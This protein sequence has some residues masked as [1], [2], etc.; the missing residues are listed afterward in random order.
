MKRQCY[1]NIVKFLDRKVEQSNVLL[2]QGARQVGKT[3]AVEE[4]LSHREAVTAINLER[5]LRTK[6]AIDQTRDFDEFTQL[7]KSRG[8]LPI[9]KK[10]ILFLDEA[11]E[12]EKLGSYVRFMKEEWRNVKVILSG[13]SMQRLFAEK[14][15]VPVGR[16][17]YQQIFPFSF[18]EYLRFLSKEDLLEEAKSLGAKLKDV[19]HETLLKYYDDF[20]FHGGMPEVVKAVAAKQGPDEVL[21]AL[22]ASQRD[23]FLRKERV[24]SY[25]FLD[26]LKGTANHIGSTAKFSHL[27]ESHYDAKRIVELLSNWHL[28]I[29]IECRGSASSQRFWPKR[30]LYDTGVLRFVRDT[31]IPKISVMNT[32][33]ERLRTPLGGIIENAVLLL[34]K[35]T[36][37]P[38]LSISGWKRGNK[39]PIE[40]DFICKR[41]AA[42]IPIEVK[43]AL[44]T[45]DRH[46]KNLQY[47]CDIHQ[48]TEAWLVSLARPSEQKIGKVIMRNI[49]AYLLEWNQ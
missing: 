6:L 29:E 16:V 8:A 35:A 41:N 23:D 49:P 12:S 22:I 39:N 17:E 45:Q 1:E 18:R 31:A 28:L 26:A 15:R 2:I 42:L 27:C 9:G 36:G 4:V 10:S 44:R 32:L 3:F 14:Q 38:G 25:L 47:Y 40:V 21:A 30:Y 5:D 34:L 43:A 24:K 20:I 11:Q 33:D 19:L 46:F 13:S 37:G 7:L 48:V